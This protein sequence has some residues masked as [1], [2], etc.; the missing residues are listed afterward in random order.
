MIVAWAV[1]T[2]ALRETGTVGDDPNG[3][4]FGLEDPKKDLQQHVQL[5]W[6]PQQIRCLSD[7][8]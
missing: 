1:P 2:D 4:G 6:Q 8:G 3:P 7:C 5:L